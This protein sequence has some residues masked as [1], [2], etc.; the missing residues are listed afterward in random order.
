MNVT[1]KIINLRKKKGWS[2]RVLAD[3]L[4]LGSSSVRAYENGRVLSTSAIQ[5][6]MKV[7]GVSYEYLTNDNCVN[8]HPENIN[9]GK[10][11]HLTDES[12]S[13]IEN[14]NKYNSG[15]TNISICNT[16]N[17]ILQNMNFADFTLNI[18]LI[19]K[20]DYIVYNCLEPICNTFED[21]DFIKMLQNKKTNSL[22][23]IFSKIEQ[24]NSNVLQVIDT[25]KLFITYY[26]G[27]DF[28]LNDMISSYKALKYFLKNTNLDTSNY[29]LEDYIDEYLTDIEE[30]IRKLETCISTFKNEISEI[31]TIYLNNI[32]IENQNQSNHEWEGI[33]GSTRNNKK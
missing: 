24:V 9:I 18:E 4:K 7:F 11:L 26:V 8:R 12:I 23:S 33:Y 28:S 25:Y 2:Q 10:K 6:Y 3:K 17:H 13:I 14:L 22:E 21:K 15:K 29:T 27:Y 16:F 30:I 5:A 1:E 19:T 20:L 31:I 32:K